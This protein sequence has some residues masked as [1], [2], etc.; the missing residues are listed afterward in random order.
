MT[1]IDEQVQEVL[2]ML[3]LKLHGSVDYALFCEVFDAVAEISIPEN[4]VLVNKT[5]PDSVV[6]YQGEG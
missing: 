3:N 4:K 1:V 2:D 5:T 6:V